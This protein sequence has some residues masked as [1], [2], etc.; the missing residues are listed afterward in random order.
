V[1]VCVCVCVCVGDTDNYIRKMP[2][3]SLIV[4][5]VNAGRFLHFLL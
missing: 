3:Y 5:S 1:C 4:T 2:V